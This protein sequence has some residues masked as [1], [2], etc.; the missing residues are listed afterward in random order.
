MSKSSSEATEKLRRSVLRM[1]RE[2]VLQSWLFVTWNPDNFT[3]KHVRYLDS[4]TSELE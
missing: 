4:V 2:T 1:A 3:C